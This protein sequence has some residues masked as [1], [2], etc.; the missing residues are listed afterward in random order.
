MGINCMGCCGE[1][2]ASSVEGSVANMLLIALRLRS[3]TLARGV[4]FKL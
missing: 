3:V 4:G 2:R 1:C